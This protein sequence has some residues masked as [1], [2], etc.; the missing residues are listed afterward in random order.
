M[1]HDNK[2][3][4]QQNL[5]K[6]K[7][8]VR[9]AEEFFKFLQIPIVS[10][11]KEHCWEKGDFYVSINDVK[12]LIEIE[13]RFKDYFHAIVFNWVTLNVPERKKANISTWFI[14]FSPEGKYCIVT[15]IDYI[16]RFP[17]KPV[18][19]KNNDMGKIKD[20]P[21]FSVA[22]S[23]DYMFYFELIWDKD[24]ADQ[25]SKLVEIKPI[26]NAKIAPGYVLRSLLT[27]TQDFF[28]NSKP[29]ENFVLTALTKLKA[30]PESDL[31]R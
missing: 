23:K 24:S 12:T 4:T 7:E 17:V 21:F 29:P 31:C 9:F 20:E 18:D 27:D 5:E 16:K 1:T 19:T 6:A 14:T 22:K 28:V 10:D 26:E 2:I 25:T 3:C 11:P 13:V 8:G 15:T 30:L